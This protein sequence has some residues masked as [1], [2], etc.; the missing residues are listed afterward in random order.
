MKNIEMEM[1]GPEIVPD[2]VVDK[3]YIRDKSGELVELDV[4]DDKDGDE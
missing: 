3:I 2:D 4:P 1:Q